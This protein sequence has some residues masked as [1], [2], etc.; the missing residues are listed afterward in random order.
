M[1]V[2]ATAALSAGVVQSHLGQVDRAVAAHEL[3][4][5]SL[6]LDAVRRAVDQELLPTLVV[7]VIRDDAATARAGFSP[8][9]RARLRQDAP[10]SVAQARTLTDRAVAAVT[11]GRATAVAPAVAEQLR[12]VRVAAD[13]GLSALPDQLNAYLSA[14]DAV[15]LAETRASVRAASAG[16]SEQ[17]APRVHDVGLVA[18]L[19]GHASRQLPLAFAA[20]VLTGQDRV[21]AARALEEATGSYEHLVHQGDA[22]ST[23]VLRNAWAQAMGSSVAE[24]IDATAVQHLDA[25]AAVSLRAASS[26]RDAVLTRLLRSAVDDALAASDADRGTSERALARAVLLCVLALVLAVASTLVVARRTAR[27]L[28]RLSEA[29]RRALDGEPLDLPLRGPR[30][31]RDVGDALRSTAEGLHRVRV[32]AEAVARGDLGPVLDRT[33]VPGRLAEAVQDSL[34]AVVHAV[35]ARDALRAELV[36]RA[37]HDPLTGLP[38]R[39]AVLSALDDAVARVAAD[40]GTTSVLFVDLDG[41]KQVNDRCGH[42]AGDEVLRTT[43]ARLR[44]QLR[45][46]DVVARLG[47]DEF[48]V[49]ARDLDA[50]GAR[51]LG[52][53]LVAAVSEP[54]E[55][56]VDGTLRTPSVGASVGL[57][58]SSGG[59][60]TPA[61]LLRKADTAVYRAKARG[62]GCV[63]VHDADLLREEAERD[64]VAHDLRAALAAGA[65]E[66]RYEPVVHATS[67]ALLAW[68]AVPHWDRAG[69]AL[70]GSEVVGAAEAAGLG[71]DLGRWLLHAAAVQTS[72]WRGRDGAPD[73]VPLT[74]RLSPAHAADGRLL[75][76]VSDALVTAEL[77]GRALALSVGE[78]CGT[79]PSVVWNLRTLQAVGVLAGLEASGSTPLRELPALPVRALALAAD[80]VSSDDPAQRLVLDLVAA[81]AQRLG[82]LVA[83]TGVTTDDQLERAVAAG[84]TAVRGPLVAAPVTADE[85][86]RW[87]ADLVEAVSARA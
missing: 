87:R 61:R 17:S 37:T 83:A 78:A 19:T 24:S 21:L 20:A 59:G 25:P 52:E 2:L 81:A 44:A 48:V 31:V 54:L 10:E 51:A 45:G 38:N 85:A 80:L 66:V 63:V 1:P 22:L 55:L 72:Q 6:E 58:V 84:A 5:A 77:P 40:G 14:S 53:R 39:A 23:S 8:L 50:D 11:P 3:L 73:D 32:Q 79:D 64:A 33:P 62:R 65:L 27:P 18:E 70:S 75:D 68:H 29:A 7:T 71:R 60:A 49:V 30:E 82:L 43:A 67:G 34:E 57:V 69:T 13:A 41:F 74:V 9:E 15:R 36:H 47:G 28:R 4:T 35:A 46:D 12:A 26:L 76:D 16:L 56:T 42:A 86:E